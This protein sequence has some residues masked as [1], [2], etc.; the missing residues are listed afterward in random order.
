VAEVEVDEMLRLMSNEAAEVSSYYTMPGSALLRIELS[1]DVLRNVL[2]DA[3]LLHRFLCNFDCFLLHVLA[4]VHRFDLGL[5][6]DL[7]LVGGVC[8]CHDGSIVVKIGIW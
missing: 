2:L 1:L 7:L 3:E 4:H 5:E 8:I 6:F